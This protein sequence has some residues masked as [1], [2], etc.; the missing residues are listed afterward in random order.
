[1][2]LIIN[3]K[4]RDFAETILWSMGLAPDSGIREPLVD[5]ENGLV[6]D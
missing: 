6:G 3:R 2:A 1:M 4:V 5:S